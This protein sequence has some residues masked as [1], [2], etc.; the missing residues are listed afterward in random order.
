MN[1]PWNLWQSLI[2]RT[3]CMTPI[4][5]SSPNGTMGRICLAF[6][7]TFQST[8][9]RVKLI[10]AVIK[11]SQ[12]PPQA[13]G[14]VHSNRSDWNPRQSRNRQRRRS[15]KRV[16]QRHRR[17]VRRAIRASS[18]ISA[19]I[20]PKLWGIRRRSRSSRWS[21]RLARRLATT[22]MNARPK[23]C[24][25][26]SR[27][28]S[29]KPSLITSRSRRCKQLLRLRSIK[30]HPSRSKISSINWAFFKCNPYSR[31]SIQEHR[32]TSSQQMP[33]NQSLITKTHPS[34]AHPET[35]SLQNLSFPKHFDHQ[36]VV[37]CTW[38]IHLVI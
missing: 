21:R 37:W 35:A 10:L 9:V 6:R 32:R 23:G 25:K 22:L 5:F 17:S 27:K 8:T 16:R 11:H 20:I 33:Q 26:K 24:P 30:R 19:E 4:L 18:R 38:S 36:I 2:A 29:L 13:S 14:I 12:K 1:T 7:I 31:L 3:T 34:K 15:G 28:K